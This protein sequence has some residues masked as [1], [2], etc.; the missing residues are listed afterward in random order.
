MKLKRC[1]QTRCSFYENEGLCPVC[2]SCGAS[3]CEINEDCTNCWNCLKDEGY[4][5]SGLPRGMLDIM[6]GIKEATDKEK[7]KKIIVI[8]EENEK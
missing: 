6:K 1:S 2:D 4:V 5:R 7:K 8:E 3:P